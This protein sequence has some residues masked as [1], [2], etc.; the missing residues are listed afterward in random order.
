MPK[1]SAMV[2][3]GDWGNGSKQCTGCLAAGSLLALLHKQVVNYTAQKAQGIVQHTSNH[4]VDV[5]PVASNVGAAFREK[6]S[7]TAVFWHSIFVE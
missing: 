3:A 7:S 5:I 1:P 4:F 2:I 6:Q